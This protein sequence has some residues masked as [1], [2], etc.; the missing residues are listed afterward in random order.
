MTFKFSA[1]L[2]RRKRNDNFFQYEIKTMISHYYSCAIT[3]FFFSKFAIFSNRQ[4]QKTSAI[5]SNNAV[6]V[7]V[8]L[9]LIMR[10]SEGLH[11]L[12]MK[13]QMCLMY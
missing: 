4:T 6:D 9:V 7:S 2:A 3:T 5:Q 13:E 8:I 11:L 12:E 10:K 1:F